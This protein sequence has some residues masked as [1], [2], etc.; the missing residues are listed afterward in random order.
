MLSFILCLAL[1]IIGYLTYGKI[2]LIFLFDPKKYNYCTKANKPSKE[3]SNLYI[4]IFL[5][6]IYIEKNINYFL[7]FKIIFN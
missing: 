3:I 2:D 7:H 6:A 5:N 1:L 4:Y